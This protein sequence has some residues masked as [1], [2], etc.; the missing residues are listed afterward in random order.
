MQVC[1]KKLERSVVFTSF[2]VSFVNTEANKVA[3][4]CAS[5]AVELTHV[6]F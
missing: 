2:D 1:G 4:L 5:K 3:H 6:L